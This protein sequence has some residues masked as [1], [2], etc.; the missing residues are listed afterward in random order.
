VRTRQG[1][2]SRVADGPPR[3]SEGPLRFLAALHGFEPDDMF[4]ARRVLEVAAAGL[5]AHRA[6]TDVVAAMADEVASMFATLD[7]PLEYLAHDVQF[8]RVVAS[9]AGNR[10]IETLVDTLSELVYEGRRSTAE[11]ARDRRESAEMHRRIYR[12]IRQRDPDRARHE[13]A[14]HLELA[15]EAQAREAAGAA[16]EPKPSPEAA[17]APRTRSAARRGAAARRPPKA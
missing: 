10:V 15:R 5:A 2:G 12:A 17:K 11:R 4:E 1:S 9:G 3:L 14:A 13:M 16:A 6:S 7:R 8:H